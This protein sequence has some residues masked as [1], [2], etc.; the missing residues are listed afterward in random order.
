[1][2][3][4][5]IIYLYIAIYCLVCGQYSTYN[6]H[7]RPRIH[8]FPNDSNHS[9]GMPGWDLMTRISSWELTYPPPRHFWIDDFPFPVWWEMWS[10]PG[11]YPLREALKGIFPEQTSETFD[12]KGAISRGTSN[13]NILYHY[14]YGTWFQPGCSSQSMLVKLKIYPHPLNPTSRGPPF[15]TFFVMYE[16]KGGGSP[17]KIGL[18]V[19]N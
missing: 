10:F 12:V 8:P 7:A 9:I 2:Y 19:W 13:Q 6:Q 16:T 1:M 11:G 15:H 3:R 18:Y 17:P 5:Q 14:K 4:F